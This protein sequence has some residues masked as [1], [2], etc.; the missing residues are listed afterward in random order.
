LVRASAAIEDVEVA[1]DV[2]PV[3][4][5]APRVP[6]EREEVAVAEVALRLVVPS[7]EAAP[8]SKDWLSAR[9]ELRM[10]EID[11][12][13]PR[14]PEGGGPGGGGRAVDPME[15]VELLELAELLDADWRPFSRLVRAAIA[16]L[17]SLSRLEV[18]DWAPINEFKVLLEN[19]EDELLSE[20]S[21]LAED[22]P[23]AFPAVS[24]SNSCSS[25]DGS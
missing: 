14:P 5:A 13:P 20:T 6:L 24:L 3:D 4:D 7:D 1:E 9:S 19:C 21:E 17:A 25:E 23:W 11:S 15:L 22:V 10:L 16:V 2:A 12:P 18:S 8:L